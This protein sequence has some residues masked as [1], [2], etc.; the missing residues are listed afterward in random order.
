RGHAVRAGVIC[1]LLLVGGLVGYFLR[2]ADPLPDVRHGFVPVTLM[3]QP[4]GAQV[5]LDDKLVGRTD[6][7]GHYVVQLDADITDV[8]WLELR[9]PGFEP[10]RRALAAY[11]NVSTVELRMRRRPIEVRV[12]TEPAGAEVWIDGEMQGF[13]P[14]AAR[15]MPVDPDKIQIKV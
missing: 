10:A 1:G 2:L 11:S 13:A 14:L 12:A 7:S 5:F 15:I 8:R 4:P 9:R 6:A 3:A